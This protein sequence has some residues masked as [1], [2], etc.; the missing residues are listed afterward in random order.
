MKRKI[1]RLLGFLA[2][3]TMA[4]SANAAVISNGTVILGVDT[5]GQLNVG[6]GAPSPVTGT[7]SVG[8]RF[9]PTGNEAT[10]H[11]CLCEGWGV[12]IGGGASGS[13][14]N[15]DGVVGLSSVSFVSDATSATSVVSMGGALQVTQ[16]FAPA[17]ETANLYR[18]AV[19]IKNTSGA[20]I[21]D[22]RYTRTF[23]WDIE[24]TT[25]SEYVTIGGSAAASAVLLAIDNGF[26]SSDPFGSRPTFGNTGDFVDAGPG[27]IGANFDFGFGA[28]KDGETF[29]FDI[30]YGAALTELGALSALAAVGAEVYSLGQA[31]SDPL[32]L[33]LARTN[34]FMFGFKGVGGQAIP[35]PTGTVPLPAGIWMLLSGIAALG[36]FKVFRR[37]VA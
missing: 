26:V 27:D 22:L 32:G 9:V 20:D 34:T 25:F 16:S 35:D 19:S 6:G 28:L 21:A 10:S 3:S 29:S 15:D 13:A 1:I 31:S 2:F 11:G 33:G 17:A 36:G 18:V 8:L 14:N 12:G 4:W 5:F 37:R 30:F 23:D 7:T 24:P